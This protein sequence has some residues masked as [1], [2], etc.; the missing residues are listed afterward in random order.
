MILR[1]SLKYL[2]PA[3]I[4]PQIASNRLIRYKASTESGQ[5]PAEA[6]RDYEEISIN[7]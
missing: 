5:S 4:I 1:Q 6:D 7:R 3:K 2:K